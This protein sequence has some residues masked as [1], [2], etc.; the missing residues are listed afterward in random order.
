[1]IKNDTGHLLKRFIPCLIFLSA[2]L[3]LFAGC[4]SNK[5]ISQNFGQ[6]YEAMLFAQTINKDAPEDK[7][8]LHG[9]SSEIGER[10]YDQYKKSYGG[11]SF[12]EQ[13][14]EMMLSNN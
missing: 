2:A 9:C 12:A 6:S 3:L 13:L 5:H 10:I 11:K 7:S 1:M 8:P 14:G 4:A